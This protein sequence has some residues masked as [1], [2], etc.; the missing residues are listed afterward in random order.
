[1][2]TNWIGTETDQVIPIEL[3]KD[4]EMDLYWLKS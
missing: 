3:A 2:K 4:E 1:M